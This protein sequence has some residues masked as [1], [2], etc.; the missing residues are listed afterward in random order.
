MSDEIAKRI[1]ALG[2]VSSLEEVST[3]VGCSVDDLLT[4]K[5]DSS[6]LT[7][8]PPFD[9]GAIVW[10]LLAAKRI[11]VERFTSGAGNVYHPDSLLA[12]AKHIVISSVRTAEI[13][14]LVEDLKEDPSLEK[15]LNEGDPDRLATAIEMTAE[16]KRKKW[17]PIDKMNS[18]TVAVARPKTASLFFDRVWTLDRSIPGSI[19]IR[20]GTIDEKIALGLVDTIIGQMAS[21]ITDT[22]ARKEKLKEVETKLTSPDFESQFA[23]FYSSLI[24]PILQRMT[25]RPI[26]T[27][28][29][30]EAS[31]K[32]MYREG[33]I[34]MVIASLDSIQW[35]DEDQLSWEHVG[36]IRED[37]NAVRQLKRMLHWLDAEMS[38][39][40]LAFIKDDINLRIDEFEDVTKKHGIKLIKGAFGTL[41][42]VNLWN[43]LIGTVIGSSIDPHAGALIG[44]SAGLTLQGTRVVFETINLHKELKATRD[45]S[46]IAFLHKI[47]SVVANE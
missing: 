21:R 15:L 27:Y 43:T 14:D 4:W 17:E 36:A 7:K 2:E 45:A 33:D 34:S 9:V 18:I 1:V 25:S 40:S 20:T 32:Q 38:G 16:M 46:P 3:I 12:L 44:F 35:I 8:G 19:G 28:V 39:K 10:D 6:A 5:S 30:G 29:A 42:D 11:S 23:A 31:L 41:L 22:D 26:Q 24:V 13:K 37:P 47:K